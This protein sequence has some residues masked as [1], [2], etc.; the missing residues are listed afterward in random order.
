MWWHA[1]A[2][3]SKKKL[4]P[5]NVQFSLVQ[6]SGACALKTTTQWSAAV[7]ALTIRGGE[8]LVASHSAITFLIGI[9]H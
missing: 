7:E 8:Y 9:G 6:L 3:E 2:E 1:E 5:E 4:T